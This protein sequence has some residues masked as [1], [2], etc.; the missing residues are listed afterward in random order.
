MTMEKQSADL[1]P[2]FVN[3]LQIGL[4]ASAEELF[5]LILDPDCCFLNTLLKNPHINEDHL[6]ALLKRRDLSEELI[7]SIY[8]KHKQSL[9]HRTILALVKNTAASGTLI[10]NLLP[11]L[12]SF[13]LVDLCYL[14]GATPDQKLAAE[15]TILQRLPTTPL[16]NKITLARRGT[17]N[18]VAALLKEGQS[19]L[20]EVCLSSPRLKEAAV[21]QFLRGATASAETIS[22][23]ARHDRWKQRPNLQLAILKNTKTPDIWFT[24][25]LPKLPVPILKQLQLSFK[26]NPSKKRLVETEWK[27]RGGI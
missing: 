18:I 13:E 24:L 1:N 23:V 3:K 11:T 19:Q 7:N 14:P 20:F 4:T 22:M 15:R 27:K 12:R 16:G 5:Q 10:R 21:F 6:L 8:K 26:A 17:A 2:D 25:W 9:S